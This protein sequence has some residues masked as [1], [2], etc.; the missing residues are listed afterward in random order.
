MMIL[1]GGIIPPIQGKLADVIRHSSI[2]LDCSICFGY[3]AFFGFAVKS[4]LSR[5][6]INYDTE[7]AA[8]GH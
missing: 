5:Q 1:G 3:L 4:I 6:G 7:I 8:G 2:L